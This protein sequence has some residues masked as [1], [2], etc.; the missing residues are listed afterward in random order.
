MGVFLKGARGMLR[1]RALISTYYK[2]R[3]HIVTF[4][5]TDRLLGDDDNL[6][7]SIEEYVSICWGSKMHFTGTSFRG[8][9][10]EE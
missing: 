8:V 5:K 1:D 7:Q 3:S 6:R 4:V 10:N 9:V 2:D